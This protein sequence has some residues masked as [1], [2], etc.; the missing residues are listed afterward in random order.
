MIYCAFIDFGSEFNA[1]GTF[2]NLIELKRYMFSFIRKHI[3]DSS[4][5]TWS[6]YYGAKRCDSFYSHGVVFCDKYSVLHYK[7]LIHHGR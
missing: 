2:P 1:T 7:T 5:V 3:T 4:C 6:I